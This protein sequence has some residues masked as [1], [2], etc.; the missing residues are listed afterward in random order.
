MNG[1]V[2]RL[3]SVLLLSGIG[4]V[5]FAAST[6]DS[7]IAWH[8]WNKKAF[9]K[10]EKE[11]K[12]ILI[13]V[14]MEGCTACNRMEK[15]TYRNDEIITLVNKHFVAINVDSEARPDIG[16]RYSDWAWPATAFLLPDATQVFAMSGNRLPENFIPILTNLIEK[17]KKGVLAPD[18]NSPYAAPPK[19]VTTDISVIRDKVRSQLDNS[20]HKYGAW[21]RFGISAEGVGARLSHLYMR[22]YAG[23]FQ[24]KKIALNASTNLIRAIDPVWGGVF[25]LG[26]NPSFKKISPRYK[27]LGVIPEKRI[28]SQA[29]A[30]SAF[31]DAYHFS[32]DT[33]YRKATA[34]IDRYLQEWM[35]AGNG[36]WYTSQRD[37]PDSLPRSWGTERYWLLATDRK[38][39]RYGIPH[40]DRA[41]YTDKNAE[42]I[43]AY[44]KAYE[45][46]K[47]T[48]YLTSATTAAT[49]LLR[50]RQQSAGWITQAKTTKAVTEDDRLHIHNDEA[51]P[52][53]SAQARFGM[54]LLKLYQATAND[55]WLNQAIKIADATLAT[56]YDK[57]N[58]GFWSTIPDETAHLIP[59]RKP[60]ETNALAA[61]FFYDL[62][63]LTKHNKYKSIAKKT[64]KAVATD[65][66]LNREGK[67]T[68][69]TA[70]ILEKLTM[71]YVE[72]SV[73]TDK[74][75]ESKAQQL[76]QTA[77]NTYHPRK[78]IHFE[79]PGRYPYKGTPTLFICNPE[80]CSLPI[81]DPMKVGE[82]ALT[83]AN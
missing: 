2:I 22:A 50:E 20:L 61:H 11:N 42:V 36:T 10:A 82:V 43:I 12:L 8:D 49:T 39:R 53:L 76:Y 60:L 46:F 71:H 40:T 32:K 67:I 18:P 25:V 64:I 27:K 62:Y 1:I 66:I 81:T 79:A 4:T 14:G 57:K 45:T 21:S 47:H 69:E 35:K 34:D 31:A 9:T 78:I 70:Q 24:L 5:S 56:L 33:R 54:A 29:N 48:D 37:R 55:I 51:R 58:G 65:R 26:I 63:I 19:A 28:S 74:P 80:R 77:V 59:P 3:L 30:M 75:Q 6:D 23:E 7:S 16:E 13:S 17:Q 41:I 73:V 44:V 15:I 38:R 72:F 83:F 68:G 52:F